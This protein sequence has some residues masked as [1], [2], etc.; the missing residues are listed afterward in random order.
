MKLSEIV[1]GGEHENYSEADIASVVEAFSTAEREPIEG[2][3]SLIRQQ[4]GDRIWIGVERA[5]E[6]KAYAVLDPVQ[7]Q[8]KAMLKLLMIYVRPTARTGKAALLLITT[9]KEKLKI[10]IILDDTNSGGVLFKGGVELVQALMKRPSLLGVGVLDLGT[11]E[12]SDPPD[13]IGDMTKRMWRGK[14][15]IFEDQGLWFDVR[16]IPLPEPGSMIWFP[17]FTE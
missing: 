10:P 4:Q 15:L 7:I 5:G 12:I 14:T 9:A 17:E 13:D 6:L 3:W 11:G 2:D 8:H 16:G 1:I